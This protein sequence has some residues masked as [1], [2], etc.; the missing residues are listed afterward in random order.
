MSPVGSVVSPAK[1]RRDIHVAMSNIC[2]PHYA[3]M[4]LLY[5]YVSVQIHIYVSN[6]MLHSSSIRP[7]DAGIYIHRK[8]RFR[9][10]YIFYIHI[11]YNIYPLQ[12]I[13]APLI[14]LCT[15]GSG[16][17]KYSRIERLQK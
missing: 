13:L 15:V 12:K 3:G 5:S 17:S 9:I 14:L 1:S 10:F 8:S 16:M 4:V 6:G 11:N 2:I 7:R